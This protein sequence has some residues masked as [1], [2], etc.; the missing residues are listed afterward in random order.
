MFILKS[1]LTKNDLQQIRTVV[2]EEVK[3]EIKPLKI[4]VDSLDKKLDNAQ[5]DI[6][7][8][9]TAVIKGHTDL[10]KRVGKVE[11]QMEN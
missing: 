10:E 4:K 7:E 5:E 6:S 9:L 11:V 8:I 3:T 2:K 1:M